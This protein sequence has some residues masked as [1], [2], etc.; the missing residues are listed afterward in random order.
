MC[1]L[2]IGFIF[3]FFSVLIRAI[4]YKTQKFAI[5]WKYAL[6]TTLSITG[7]VLTCVGFITLAHAP[8]RPGT[9]YSVIL[10]VL[11][12]LSA[13]IISGYLA[14]TYQ[15]AGKNDKY[16]PNIIS[17]CF[18]LLFYLLFGAVSFYIG[19]SEQIHNAEYA[20]TIIPIIMG[21]IL[22]VNSLFDFWDYNIEEKECGGG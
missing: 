15:E 9:D 6:L 11:S 10:T 19:K 2:F 3:Q 5:N 1:W 12:L 18:T 13:G 14:F 17:I 20:S 21:V 7:C 4:A 16:F 22:A 8:A